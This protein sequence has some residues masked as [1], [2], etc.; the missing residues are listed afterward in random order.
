MT[1]NTE[2][3]KANRPT[4][5]TLISLFLVAGPLLLFYSFF[6]GNTLQG[7]GVGFLVYFAVVSIGFIVCGIGFWMMR[8]WA[9]YTYTVLAVIIQI[10]LLVMGRWNLFSLL[11]AAVVLFFGYRN[12]SKMS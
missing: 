3:A 9:V 4:S 5:I 7:Q 1:V 12:L 11:L 10:A 8:K 2:A 6:R